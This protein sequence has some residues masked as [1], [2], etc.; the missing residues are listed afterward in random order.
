MFFVKQVI[1]HRA[2]SAITELIEDKFVFAL[3]SQ[4][5]ILDLLIFKFGGSSC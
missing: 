5:L 3:L 4:I 2:N 1:G